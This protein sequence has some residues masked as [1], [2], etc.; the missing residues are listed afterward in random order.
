MN[1]KRLEEKEIH[2][3]L[4]FISH[5]LGGLLVKQALIEARLNDRK[6]RCLRA[7]TCGLVFFATPHAGG[8]K[9]V[10]FGVEI[11]KYIHCMEACADSG[12][13]TRAGVASI[14]SKI[15]SAMTGEP[16]NSLLATLEKDS[17]LNEISS[18]QF[19]HQINDYE[20]LSFYE[21]KPM[22]VKIKQRKIFPQITSMVR[23]LCLHCRLAHDSRSISSIGH[24]L[25]WALYHSH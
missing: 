18:D 13:C 2:R 17:L 4:I 25:N 14:A 7:S 6:Y 3:P 10:C 22:D 8:N 1:N 11:Y 19:H 21:T 16:S 9:C 20:I 15:C 12:T 24:P 23:A 5:S